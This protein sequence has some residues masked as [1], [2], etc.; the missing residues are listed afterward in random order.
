M[1]AMARILVLAGAVAAVIPARADAAPALTC[2]N[3]EQERA[4]VVGGHTVKLAAA[5]KAVHR[6]PS[7]VIGARLCHGAKGLEYVLTLLAHDGK[8]TRATVD[9]DLGTVAGRR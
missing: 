4:A 2:L 3:K 5:I 8:V 9:A 7:E 6:H 1:R